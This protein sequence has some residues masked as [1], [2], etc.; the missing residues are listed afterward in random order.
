MT[1][2]AEMLADGSTRR[3]MADIS[4]FFS[5]SKVQRDA[6]EDERTRLAR[7]LH[8]GVLQTLTGVTLQLEH[9]SRLI[10]TDP[11]GA[12]AHLMTIGNLIAAEQRELRTFIDRLKLVAGKSLASSAELATALE[13]LRERSE[14]LG[15]VRVALTV[16]GRGS[17]PRS[18]GDEIYRIVQEALA[19][20]ARHAHAQSARVKVTIGLDKVRIA[21][22]DDGCGFPFHGEHDLASL[23]A[24]NR[25]PVSLRGRVANLRGELVLTSSLSGSSLDISLPIDQPALDWVRSRTDQSGNSADTPRN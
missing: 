1:P 18:M 10:A 15:G 6:V 11:D 2:G 5:K 9:A 19:N 21:V 17:I 7:D 8:D 16:D 13:K 14:Q 25:G 23:A 20:V 22:S 4:R 3:V 24:R 12:R